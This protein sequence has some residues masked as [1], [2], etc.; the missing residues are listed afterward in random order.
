M[1]SVTVF[2]PQCWRAD[3]LATALMVMGEERAIEFTRQH[4][5]PCLLWVRA[6]TLHN[7]LRAVRSPR[8]EGW[9]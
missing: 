4:E 9:L 3:A 7:G 6:E 2:D 5:I 1:V 8:L